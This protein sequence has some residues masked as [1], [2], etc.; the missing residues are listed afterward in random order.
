MSRLSLSAPW[1][2]YYREVE[3]L[4][5]DD[6]EVN[7]VY[8]EDDNELKLYV[9]N[10]T[11][12]EALTQLLPVEKQFGNVTLKITVIPANNTKSTKISLFQDAFKDNPALAY[13]KTIDGI[14][15]NPIS[16]VV[17]EGK[18]VQYFN[19]SMADINGV[20][21]TLYQDIA[22]N[23]FGEQDGI[24]FCTDLVDEDYE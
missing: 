21:S 5:E 22:K 4:F 19:D 11:K 17:F 3:A 8:N 13:I 24:F 1:V 2:T 20:C 7:V 18:V 12:A 9:N 16:Y 15:S 14:F 6:P 10:S 23:V